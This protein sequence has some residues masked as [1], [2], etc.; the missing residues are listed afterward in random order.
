MRFDVFEYTNHGGRSY[1]EDAIGHKVIG[2]NGVFLVADG[3]GGHNYGELASACV[4]DTLLDGFSGSFGGNASGWLSSAITRANNNVL[5][6]QQEKNDVLKSTVVALAIEEGRASWANVGDSRLYYLH[7]G[8]IASYTNDHSVAYK[9]FKGGE[10]TRDQLRTD[11]DQSAL[12][13]SIGSVD[14]N[15]VELYDYNTYV[16][17][18]DAFMLCSDGVWEFISD[19]E[20]VIDL[21]KAH[22]AREWAELLLLR[23]MERIQGGNDNLTIQTIM[24]WD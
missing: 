11:E 22:D 2:N 1:N 7:N 18:G 21:M 14:R 9:K 20:I 10:I 13:R 12:L 3:L 24:I 16:Q 5:A 23:M 19:E 15:E 6:I 8:E 4:R 17:P